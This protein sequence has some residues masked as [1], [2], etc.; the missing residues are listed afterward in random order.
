RQRDALR[1]GDHHRH[2][3][4][5]ADVAVVVRECEH[6]VVAALEYLFLD[7]DP[8]AREEA[9]GDAE[10][11]RPRVCDRQR[12]DRDRRQRRLAR[13]SGGRAAEGG[14]KQREHA[15]G[16]GE[17]TVDVHP[18]PLAVTFVF[19]ESSSRRSSPTATSRPPWK[20]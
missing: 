4:E 3:A 10:I 7:L 14:G 11:Q 9:L 18:F 19:T 1:A 13:R 2:V 15:G 12:V 16:E 8:T 5:V 6:D 20:M 17:P